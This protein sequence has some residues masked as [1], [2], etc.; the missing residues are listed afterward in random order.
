M[1][2]QLRLIT[3]RTREQAAGLHKGKSSAAYQEATRFAEMNPQDMEYLGVTEG[4]LVRIRA[5]GGAVELK[6]RPGQLPA[7]LI[8]VPLGDAANSLVG[9]N[10]G[11]TG[12]PGFK[13]LPVEVEAV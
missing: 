8:F 12:M 11:G 13:G 10:T 4:A 5:E 3:G 1:S 2:K 7:G 9:P 6:A